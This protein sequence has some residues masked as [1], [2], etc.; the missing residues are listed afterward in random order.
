MANSPD[1]P[2]NLEGKLLLADPSLRDGTFNKTVIFLTE[3]SAEDGAY[4]L[5]LNQPTDQTVGDI[6]PKEEFKDLQSVPVHIG[7]PIDQ[8]HLTFA[9]FSTKKNKRLNLTT[10]ISA[11]DAIQSSQQPGMLVRAFAGHSGWTPGQLE[12]ELRKNTWITTQADGSLLKTEHE[13]S[14]WADL[15]RNISPFHKVLAEAPDDIFMN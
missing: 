7:G 9:V 6:L 2:I 8:E 14:L 10:R 5:I 4:G 15:L 11:E 3:H 1:S 12:S 13:K